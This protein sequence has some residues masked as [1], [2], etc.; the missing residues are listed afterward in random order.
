MTEAYAR[1][2]GALLLVLLST[3][4]FTN[5]IEWLGHKLRLGEGAVGS[6][7]AAWGTALP[8]VLVPLVAIFSGKGTAIR[9]DI[10]VGAILGAP[11]MLST[12][13]FGLLGLAVLFFSRAGLRQKRLFPRRSVGRRD[14]TFFVL[15]FA[16]ALGAGFLPPLGKTIVAVG[17]LA[18]YAGFVV[19]VIAR[20]RGTFKE[21]EQIPALYFQPRGE[22]PSTAAVIIQVL[23]AF[24]WMVVGAEIFVGGIERLADGLGIRPFILAVLVVP[25]ATE[26]PELLNSLLWLSR[27]KDT[28]AFG[29]VTGAMAFQ[30][31]VVPAV[32]IMLTPWRLGPVEL[33]SGLLALAAGGVILRSFWL[34][35]GITPGILLSAG[36]LYLVF[37]FLVWGGL[38]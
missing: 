30:A 21:R 18:V 26:L 15:V 9:Q 32:G 34:R 31:S 28:L 7:L 17:L 3:V 16:V 24:V 20:G 29:N 6:T 5:G 37:V 23:V 36:G 38:L 19:W 8:E 22:E 11:L 13:A 12:L 33:G 2:V 4:F 35:R 1:L 14:L 25:L 27:R 10:G